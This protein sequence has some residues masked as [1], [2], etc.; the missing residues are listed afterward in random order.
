MGSDQDA[1]AHTL[2]LLADLRALCHK[3]AEGNDSYAHEVHRL[4]QQLNN[5]NLH[6]LDHELSFRVVQLAPGYYGE[7]LRT[8]SANANLSLAHAALQVAVKQNTNTT[9][10]LQYPGGV[11]GR[12]DPPGTKIEDK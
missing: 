7:T 3:I 6:G 2:G 9:W 4:L 1:E 5:P 11:A 10:L 8:V 12:Y